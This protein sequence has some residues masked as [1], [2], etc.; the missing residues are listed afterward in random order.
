MPV[1]WDIKDKVIAVTGAASGIGLAVAELLASQGVH[2]SMADLTEKALNEAADRLSSAG[3]SVMAT[4]VDVRE[5][6]QVNSWIEKT[7]AKF[8]KLDGAVNMAGVVPKVINIE[9]VEHH[10]TPD[11]KF[12][13][14][15]NLTGTFHCMRAQLGVM[16]D[17]GSIVNAASIAGV[18]GFPKNAAYTASKT[19]VIGL[20]RAACKEVGHREI[21]INCVAPGIID[22]PMQAAA[23]ATRGG[24]I[25]WKHQI[26]RRG[27]PQEVASLVAWLLCDESKF[28]TGAVHHIDGGWC[29]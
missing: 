9:D 3:Y 4:V 6:D 22:T 8:G 28:I 16:K 26:Q 7:V 21:R 25:T 23:K 12:V 1:N 19:G 29:C 17:Q 27:T 5:E 2:V 11:W 20:S 24:E 15:V 18:T 14:D 13:L 10:N